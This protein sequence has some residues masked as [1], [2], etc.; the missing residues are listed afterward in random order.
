MMR[1]GITAEMTRQISG[2]FPYTLDL[3]VDHAGVDNFRRLIRGCGQILAL[4]EVAEDHVHL[5]V[6]CIDEDLV[7][8]PGARLS[9][10]SDLA[11][12]E[13]GCRIR[14]GSQGTG[15]ASGILSRAPR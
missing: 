6:G 14:S 4:D 9:C 2:R 10:R 5:V 15:P 13:A 3:H 8:F 7:S 12:A 11:Y 1:H